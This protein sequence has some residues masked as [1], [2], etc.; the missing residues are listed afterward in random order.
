M[1]YRSDHDAALA[2]VDALEHENA[3]L[4]RK[5]AAPRPTWRVRRRQYWPAVAALPIGAVAAFAFGGGE[6]SVHGGSELEM[7]AR[8]LAAK[9]V[10][11]ATDTDPHGRAL[12]A[13]WAARPLG[14][15]AEIR[16]RLNENLSI[17]ERRALE[18]WRETEDLL[19]HESRSLI[20][21]YANGPYDVDSYA[22]SRQRWRDY[23]EAYADR[24][25]AIVAWRTVTGRR[26]GD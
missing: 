15:E 5:L 23:D 2:R 7:C 8:T 26:V 13:A 6:P 1:T 21:Y 11:D 4:Q 3:A 24:Q 12:P 25:L 17:R 20:T 10:L 19:A 14:C 16:A 18:R 22:S 9:P